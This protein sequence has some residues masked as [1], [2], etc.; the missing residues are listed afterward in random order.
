MPFLGDYVY[1]NPQPSVGGE[2]SRQ[3]SLT[4]LGAYILSVIL[5]FLPLLD[6]MDKFL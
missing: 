2:G 6:S 5:A 4:Y 3:L 1:L